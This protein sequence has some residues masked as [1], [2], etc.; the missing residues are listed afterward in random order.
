[1]E[2]TAR[3]PEWRQRPGARPAGSWTKQR[4]SRPA[5]R[6]CGRPSGMAGVFRFTATCIN[7]SIGR[8]PAQGGAPPAISTI[9]QPKA[10]RSECGPG[11]PSHGPLRH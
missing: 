1:M 7:I 3:V 10:Q 8:I 9:T 6:A 4:S 11:A 2:Y 5:A